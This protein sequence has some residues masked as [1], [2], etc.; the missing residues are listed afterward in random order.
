MAMGAPGLCPEYHE[1]YYGG[2][3]FD[4]DGNNIA[5]VTQMKE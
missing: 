2:F 4:P 3:V 5:A 1:H